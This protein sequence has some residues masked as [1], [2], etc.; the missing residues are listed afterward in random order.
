VNTDFEDRLAE[1]LNQSVDARL[2]TR[3]AAPPFEATPAGDRPADELAERRRRRYTFLAVAATVAAIVVAAF[4]LHALTPGSRHHKTAV[5][6]SPPP[7]SVT[8]G[9]ARIVLPT[10]WVARPY[11]EYLKKGFGIGYTQAW[12]LT[13][14]STPASTANNA[15]PVTFGAMTGRDVQLD[16]DEQGGL[17]AN[18][19]YCFQGQRIAS[20]VAQGDIRPFGGRL[21]FWYREDVRCTSSAA[22]VHYAQYVVAGTPAYILYTGTSNASTRSAMSSIAQHSTLPRQTSGLLLA[23]IGR[24]TRMTGSGSA[25]RLTLTRVYATG[26]SAKNRY[27]DIPGQTVSYTVTTALLHS[28]ALQGPIRKGSIVKIQTNGTAVT[29]IYGYQAK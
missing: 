17:P 19:E 3:Q 14:R 7:N 13:P 9:G 26:A 1:L 28:G 11:S 5:P 18:A 15:C 8:L 24:I 21:A 23:D 12:C 6:P 2:G 27:V 4:A 29:A 22:P 20:D 10:G 16:P 25:V